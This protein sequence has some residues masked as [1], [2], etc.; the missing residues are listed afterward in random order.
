MILLVD[1]EDMIRDLVREIL[2]AGGYTVLEAR[3]GG[4]ALLLSERQKG[5]IHLMVSD[6]EMPLISGR[7]LAKRLAPL[8]PEMR[9]LYMS[10]SAA[11]GLFQRGMLEVGSAFLQKPFT[12]DTLESKVRS[13]LD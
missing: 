9:V 8:R 10:G 1:D 12:P 4:E 13:L 6:L 11:D 2:R 3:H 7:D 5:P